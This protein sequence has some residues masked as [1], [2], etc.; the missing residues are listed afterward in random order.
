MS[1]TRE[2]V[3]EI[4]D[5]VQYWSGVVPLATMGDLRALCDEWEAQRKRLDD[6]ETARQSM[7]PPAPEKRSSVTPSP[8][9]PES[10]E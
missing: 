5:S 1:L 2:R 6:Y 9:F 4:R 7:K 10:S 8:I 3:K